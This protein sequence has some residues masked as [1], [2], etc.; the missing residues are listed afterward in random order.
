[1]CPG[2]VA[3]KSCDVLAQARIAWTRPIPCRL[4][5]ACNSSAVG[6]FVNRGAATDPTSVQRGTNPSHSHTPFPPDKSPSS[7]LPSRSLQHIHNDSQA[8]L[9]L[10]LG[11]QLPVWGN[12]AEGALWGRKGGC[13]DWFLGGLQTWLPWFGVMY[14]LRRCTS[15]HN[16]SQYHSQYTGSAMCDC[17]DAILHAA[18]ASFL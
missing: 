18:Q 17:S 4:T 10:W 3:F 5:T 9:L 15:T 1:M 13:Y 12:R 11:C 7:P 14:F 16:P 6:L 8:I 2:I